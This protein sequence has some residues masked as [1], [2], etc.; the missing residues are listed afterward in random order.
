MFNDERR[1]EVEAYQSLGRVCRIAFELLQGNDFNPTPPA[2]GQPLQPLTYADV[3]GRYGLVEG[4]FYGREKPDELILEYVNIPSDMGSK[5]AT[6]KFISYHLNAL[7]VPYQHSV[8]STAN[9]PRSFQRAT[10]HEGIHHPMLFPENAIAILRWLQWRIS[11]SAYAIDSLRRVY[12]SDLRIK[13]HRFNL[14]LASQEAARYS[15]AATYD[16]GDRISNTTRVL[17]KFLFPSEFETGRMTSDIRNLEFKKT[18]A[19]TKVGQHQYDACL[20]MSTAIESLKAMANDVP[21]VS[22]RSG[23]ASERTVERFA[24]LKAILREMARI[25]DGIEQ[26]RPLLSYLKKASK[27]LTRLRPRYATK[28]RASVEVTAVLQASANAILNDFESNHAKLED[29]VRS[30]ADMSSSGTSNLAS[31][32][33]RFLEA[34]G[35]VRSFRKRYDQGVR[36]LLAYLAN[37]LQQSLTGQASQKT[38]RPLA[39]ALFTAIELMMTSERFVR[40]VPTLDAQLDLSATLRAMLPDMNTF[41]T[42]AARMHVNATVGCVT[43]A[44]CFRDVPDIIKNHP[45]RAYYTPMIRQSRGFDTLNGYLDEGRTLAKFHCFLPTADMIFTDGISEPCRRPP[46]LVRDTAA[47]AR[48][49]RAGRGKPKSIEALLREARGVQEESDEIQLTEADQRQQ[50]LEADDDYDFDIGGLD[51]EAEG[52]RRGAGY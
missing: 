4:A 6:A 19:V 39:T 34:Y 22:L 46:E 15:L 42:Y 52:G 11:T 16:E 36:G 43:S 49:T 32:K 41:T 26:A 20:Y 13:N 51:D 45:D 30:Y 8:H 28:Y 12:Q 24:E 27:I 1:I 2:V 40:N 47:I 10:Y 50:K 18:I 21:P 14:E 35:S 3:A 44:A 25:A 5:R 38:T 31:F 29:A 48:A 9:D 7:L 17:A 37:E 23:A 33:D